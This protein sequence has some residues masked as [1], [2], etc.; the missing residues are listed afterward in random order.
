MR[1]ETSA[2]DVKGHI[3]IP[4]MV[5]PFDTPTGFSLGMTLRQFYAAQALMGWVASTAGTPTA[6]LIGKA[7]EFSFKAAD[8]LIAFEKAEAAGKPETIVGRP[9]TIV[10][11]PKLVG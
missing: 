9:S 8:N 10:G 2:V 11:R 4:G 1:A 7:A 3:L 6:N 5:Y